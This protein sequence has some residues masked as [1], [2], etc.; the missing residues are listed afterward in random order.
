MPSAARPLSRLPAPASLV[1]IRVHCVDPAYVRKLAMAG[2][3]YRNLR[4]DQLV[5]LRIHGVTPAFVR[6][7]AAGYKR[8]TLEQLVALRIH[9][10]DP[11]D[12]SLANAALRRGN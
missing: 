7:M 11:N 5:S 6:D 9:G 12:A 2:P 4:A 8:L 1:K 3:G 10:V